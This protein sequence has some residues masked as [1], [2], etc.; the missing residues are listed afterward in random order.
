MDI[1]AAYPDGMEIGF[2]RE[3][4]KVDIDSGDTNDFELTVPEKDYSDKYQMGNLIYAPGTEWGGVIG[5]VKTDSATSTIKVKGDTWRGMLAKKIIEPPSGK[6][7]LTMEGDL[8]LALE[9]VIG[10]K[11]SGL[12]SADSTLT[13]VNIKYTFDRYTDMLTGLTKMLKSV[14]MR[15]D[16]RW[17][18]E[19]GCAIVKATPIADY[20]EDIELNQDMRV[21][22]ATRN[23]RRGINHLICLGSGELTERQVAHLYLQPD[24]SVSQNQHYTGIDERTAVYDY[25]NAESI[26][27]LI[28]GGIE[29]LKE[30]ADY[31]ELSMKVED[32]NAE[33]G[34]IVGGRDR[35]TGLSMK[36]PITGK[37]LRITGK[38]QSIEYKIGD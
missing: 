9:E 16:I 7:Y 2:I 18:D 3:C 22:F 36:K 28:S 6:A 19:S 20:S 32:V 31:S 35:I 29:R 1:I 5:D 8:G 37:I 27:E 23:Y 33:I 25:S 34:D 14:D 4:T 17:S 11:F 10:D 30:L 12:I 13:G 15:L 38:K 26:E 21:N 24:G